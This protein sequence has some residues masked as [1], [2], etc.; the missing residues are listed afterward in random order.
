MILL[1]EALIFFPFHIYFKCR[2]F[3]KP[4]ISAWFHLAF[5]SGRNIIPLGICCNV[6]SWATWPEWSVA[7]QPAWIA[8]LM[9]TFKK[10]STGCSLEISVLPSTKK[11]CL[12]VSCYSLAN[13]VGG[14]GEKAFILFQCLQL[15][16]FHSFSCRLKP[17]WC[18]KMSL[19][20]LLVLPE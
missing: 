13:F 3:P 16:N 8:A 15:S 17:R 14:R 2:R 10:K 20:V 5:N 7:L 9:F 4:G 18:V 12:L 19:P 1:S 6:D 11:D